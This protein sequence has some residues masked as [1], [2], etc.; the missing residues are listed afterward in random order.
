MNTKKF[1]FIFF[2]KLGLPFVGLS[3]WISLSSAKRK[4]KNMVDDPESFMLSERYQYLYRMVNKAIFCANTKVKVKGIKNVPKKPA[5]FVVNHKSNFDV[6]V[7]LKAFSKFQEERG[8][9]PTTFVS[10][11]EMEQTKKISCVAKMIN[12]IFLDR[13]NLRDALRVINEEKKILSDGQ[14]SMT[15]FI[16]GTR[17]KEDKFGEFKAAALEPAYATFCPIVPVV[18]YGTL[19]VEKDQKKNI[20]KYKEIT[21][22]FLEPMKYKTFINLNKE[23]VANKLKESMEKRYMEIKENPYWKENDE[24]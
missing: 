9:L 24:E 8:V 15:V 16:E 10:K 13:A 19:G 14:Q 5:L 11:K 18:I 1:F 3:L 6:L 17:I 23:T 22:E 12:T 7:Y 2:H 21:V 4:Y 20:F